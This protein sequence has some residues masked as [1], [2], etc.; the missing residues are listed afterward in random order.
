MPKELI[1]KSI[2]CEI[3]AKNR[4]WLF[5]PKCHAVQISNK[6]FLNVCLPVVNN[7]TNTPIVTPPG[8]LIL[9]TPMQVCPRF[10]L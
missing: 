10:T 1:N 5:L 4:L 9:A 7:D 2:T 6:R 8:I 3:L